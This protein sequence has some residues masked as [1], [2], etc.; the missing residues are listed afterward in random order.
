[1][2]EPK[3]D[4]AAPAPVE[5]HA[6]DA[7]GSRLTIQGFASGLLS[8]MG[9]NPTITARDISGEIR[10][11][12]SALDAAQVQLRI[13]TASLSA[14]NEMSDSDR[15]EIERTMHEQ[16]L[17]TATYPEIVFA[18]AKA[19]IETVSEGRLRVEVEGTLTLHGV[20]R[21]QRVSA[22]VFLTGDTM[23]AQGEFTIRQ[24]EFGIK[25]VSVAGGMLKLKD[26]L[27]CSFDVVAR[28][29]T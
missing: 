27:R 2:S 26:E 21:P 1:M 7:K 24:T 8:T 17:E 22:Q 14:Q 25:L 10:F 18:S 11:A 9:H 15:R 29:A 4:V 6:I 13:V 3:N 16:V 5:R 23:R 19:T 20:T 12:P 28:K